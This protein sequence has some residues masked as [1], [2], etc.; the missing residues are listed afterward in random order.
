MC[1]L[2]VNARVGNRSR[3]RRRPPDFASSSETPGGYVGQAVLEMRGRAWIRNDPH[4]SPQILSTALRDKIGL[5]PSAALEDENDDEDEYE[6][7]RHAWPTT[8]LN[9]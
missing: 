2:E 4:L 3:I 7:N 9:H 8:R 1:G 5:I 6:N